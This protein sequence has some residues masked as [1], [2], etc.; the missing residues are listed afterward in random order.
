MSYENADHRGRSRSGGKE[1]TYSFRNN[2]LIDQMFPQPLDQFHLL[3]RTEAGDR[4]LDD[5]AQ[6]NLIHSDEAV[7]VHIC[8]ETHDKLAVHPVGNTAMSGNRIT[9]I[10][11]LERAFETGGKEPAEG[12]DKRCE[13]GEDEDMHLHRCHGEGLHVRKPDGEAVSVGDKDGVRVALETG[14]DVCSE[15]LC[16]SAL[17]PVVH[18]ENLHLRGR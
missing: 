4:H 1:E 12:C 16:S 6:R 17:F 14:P 18:Q 10:L 9:E 7:V 3:L 13:C 15:I 11:D 8:E 2:P 5:T